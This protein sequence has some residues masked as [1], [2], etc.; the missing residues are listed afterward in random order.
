M[1]K[2]RWEKTGK[3]LIT[4]GLL[5][6][7]TVGL[8]ACGGGTDSGASAAGESTDSALK[9]TNVSYDPTRELYQAYNEAFI[10]HYQEETGETPEI[11]Q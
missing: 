4:A 11:V 3:R 10:A 7:L 9:I 5:A 1:K 2:I 6:A 8:T